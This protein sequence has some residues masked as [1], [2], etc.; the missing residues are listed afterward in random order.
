MGV[1]FSYNYIR[2][3]EMPNRLGISSDLFFNNHT[4][5]VG[6][7]SNNQDLINT[8]YLKYT[9][10]NCLLKINTGIGVYLEF[11][12]EIAFLNKARSEQQLA[13]A[14]ATDYEPRTANVTKDYTRL[15]VIM[16]SGIGTELKLFTFKKKN[17]YKLNLER[18]MSRLYQRNDESIYLKVGGRLNYSI[19]DIKNGSGSAD[20]FNNVIN[21]HIQT[22]IVSV[23]LVVGLCYKFY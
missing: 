3:E 19:V 8:V 15:N 18:K 17:K 6:Y 1:N 13:L 7:N 4:I 21:S 12:P 10:L 11:G 9:N 16:V 20:G 5:Q 23:G 14:T 2:I 22:R